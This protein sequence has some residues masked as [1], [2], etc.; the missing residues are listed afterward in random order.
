MGAKV[1]NRLATLHGGNIKWSLTILCALGFIFLLLLNRN[2]SSQLIFR[3]CSSQHLCSSSLPLCL[4]NRWSIHYYRSLCWFPLFWGYTLN[5]TWA[6]I[7]FTII[8]VGINIT[9]F[10]QYFL[11]FSA[12]P[13]CYSDYPDAYAKWNTVLSHLSAHSSH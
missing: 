11:S 10:P 12:I 6:K 9:F 8:F 13:W 1:F 5:S 4:F 3:Y 2:R 7:H